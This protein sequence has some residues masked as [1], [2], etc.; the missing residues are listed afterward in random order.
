MACRYRSYWVYCNNNPPWG[1]VGDEPN[2]QVWGTI[3][4]G[5]TPR[6]QKRPLHSRFPA[7]ISVGGADRFLED[8]SPDI[9]RDWFF[10]KVVEAKVV[11][12]V[13]LGWFKVFPDIQDHLGEVQ[14]QR[15]QSV[16]QEQGLPQRVNFLKNCINKGRL[17]LSLSRKKLKKSGEKLKEN[18]ENPRKK[19]N[20]HI[21]FKKWRNLHNKIKYFWRKP[22]EFCRKT[23]EFYRKTQEISKILNIHLHWLPKIWRKRKPALK[24]KA[25][26]R[27]NAQK[28]QMGLKQFS[29]PKQLVWAATSGKK[30]TNIAQCR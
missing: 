18:W 26:E 17:S 20:F 13:K 23:Q 1:I 11:Q 7:L 2:P 22:D 21:F 30:K 8:L 6:V 15:H 10:G 24:S 14:P 5:L 28:F 19:Q 4:S 16:G 9:P 29:R 3:G 27:M 25:V 12:H